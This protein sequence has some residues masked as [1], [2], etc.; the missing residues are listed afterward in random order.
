MKD[1]SPSITI[2]YLNLILMLI[3][4]FISANLIASKW[5]HF[6]II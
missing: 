1:I 2:Y 3:A 6:D 5:L 4:N